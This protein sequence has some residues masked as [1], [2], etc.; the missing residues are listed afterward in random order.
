ML[1]LWRSY[2]N[3]VS[4]VKEGFLGMWEVV[5]VDDSFINLQLLGWKTQNSCGDFGALKRIS[6]A[7]I[8]EHESA[9]HQLAHYLRIIV[10]KNY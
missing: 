3:A 4:L 9:V 1:F 6:I 2:L 7:L 8:H 10:S 5:K